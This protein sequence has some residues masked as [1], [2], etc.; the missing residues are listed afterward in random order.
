MESHLKMLRYAW[1]Q[2]P[3]ERRC[4]RGEWLGQSGGWTLPAFNYILEARVKLPGDREY[5]I[6]AYAAYI[7]REGP[8]GW[9]VE[10]GRGGPPCQPWGRPASKAQLEDLVRAG[11][12]MKEDRDLDRVICW[13]F[14]A[15]G[16]T[17]PDRKYAQ[18]RELP[19]SDLAQVNALLSHFG[20]KQLELEVTA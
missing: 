1:S 19:I 17:E 3:A 18:E 20:L 10:S 8:V 16:F 4:V 14:S 7:E 5:P 12:A 15:S 2:A 9:A 6:D 13:F 11:R